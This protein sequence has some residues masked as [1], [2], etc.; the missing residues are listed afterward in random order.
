MRSGPS[1]ALPMQ[2]AAPV[3]MQRQSADQPG[4]RS[5]GR[6]IVLF[7]SDEPRTEFLFEGTIY[8]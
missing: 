8:G 6:T 7:A 4:A 3:L 5:T 1:R 2:T